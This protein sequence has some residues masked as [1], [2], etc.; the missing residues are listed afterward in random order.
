[1]QESK[2][3]KIAKDI[4]KK[5]I[6]LTL[7]TKDQDIPWATPLFYCADD[8]FNFY[9]SSQMDS[10]HV[11]YLLKNPTVAFAIFD[12]HQEEGTGNGI[13]A[14]GKA[15]LVIDSE[16]KEVLKWYHTNFFEIGPKTFKGGSL[17]RLFKIV[18]DHFYIQN[19]DSKVDK[20]I[21]VR[22]L[23]RF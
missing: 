22:L 13:Q 8:K 4:I 20:R 1:M 3:I 6:H 17:Y 19:P 18:P 7:A 23:E 10:L 9:F 15:F 12:S 5:N 2:L 16:I 11:K 14:S 21:E